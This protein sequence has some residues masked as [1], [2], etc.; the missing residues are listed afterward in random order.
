MRPAIVL[1]V[2]NALG[3]GKVP[4]DASLCV[5]FFHTSSLIV[6]DLPC[7]DDDDYRRSRLST[8]KVFGEAVALLAS[9]ALMTQAFA[10]IQKNMV[11][12]TKEVGQIALSC[13]TKGSGLLGATG[14]Q[15]FDLFPKGEEAFHARQ[16]IAM[17]TVSL[18]ELSFVLG[19]LF[20]GGSI[21]QIEE[22]KKASY[23]FGMAFQI[24]D[25]LDD[26]EKD[27]LLKKNSNIANCLGEEET[28]NLLENEIACFEKQV[29]KV[30]IFN[31]EFQELTSILMRVS[32]C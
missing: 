10:I 9:Y 4:L 32:P 6:D 12:V 11:D 26:R 25:D 28:L 22:I 16:V 13:A 23:H 1:M 14:G 3:F 20:G 30:G 18:F 21:S 24:A 15:F 31:E 29:K 5:E 2:A 27:L 8:H 7:M 19:F 17:K